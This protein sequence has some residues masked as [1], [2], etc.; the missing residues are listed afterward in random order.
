MQRRRAMRGLAAGLLCLLLVACAS[1]N[2][3]SWPTLATT[4]PPAPTST[5]PS[6]PVAITH[7]VITCPDPATSNPAGKS[8]IPVDFCP[9]EET[10]IYAA[11]AYID[12]TVASLT[13]LPG[14]FGCPPFM[15]M[16]PS[17][18]IGQVA[19]YV[20]FT[21][22]AKVAALTL[23]AQI[24]LAVPPPTVFTATVVALQVPPPNW[25]VP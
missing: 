17:V 19:A 5:P 8:F 21:G 16:C 13:I 20:T 6:S 15:E 9:A 1:P 4:P 18:V 25:I 12:H 7:V 22:T 3:T 23:N 14:G 24:S 10:A 2:V 11:V